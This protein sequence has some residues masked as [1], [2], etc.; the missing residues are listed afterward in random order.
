MA[1]M[2]MG[3]CMW[4]GNESMECSTRS[5]AGIGAQAPNGYLTRGAQALNGY[6]RGAQVPTDPRLP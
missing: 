5:C 6:T 3:A 1:T 2:R 4:L